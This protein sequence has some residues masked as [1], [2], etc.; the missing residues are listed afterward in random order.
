VSEGSYCDGMSPQIYFNPSCSK[1]RTAL[2]ILEEHEVQA[3]IVRYL[4][5]PPTLADLKALMAALGIDDPRA[6]MRT[7]EPAYTEL[8]LA[9][10]AGDE[11]LEAIT[12]HPIL[13]ERPIFVIG[14]RAVIARPPERLLELL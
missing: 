9:D 6:M 11:L 4:D 8:S 12:S 10:Q 3:E 1:C 2:S 13:L 14:N 5:T 7:G